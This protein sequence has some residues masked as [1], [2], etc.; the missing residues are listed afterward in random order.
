MNRRDWN[1]L[2]LVPPPGI[3]L[4]IS[5]AGSPSTQCNPQ[6]PASENS[7]EKGYLPED[8]GARAAEVRRLDE[9]KGGG[10]AGGGWGARYSWS[11]SSLS[12]E[13]R[14]GQQAGGWAL[15]DLR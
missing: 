8:N 4:R 5:A 14:S 3:D 9:P 12:A 1:G 10:E 13:L 2:M 11:P 6:P 15:G 7:F